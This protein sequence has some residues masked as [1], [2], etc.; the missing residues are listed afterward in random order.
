MERL[1][2]EMI[3]YFRGDARRISHFIKVRSFAIQ[4]SEM[5]QIPAHTREIIETAALVHDI[6]IREAERL[7]GYN[8]GKL[9]EEL[10]PGPARTVLSKLAYKDDMV[11]RV[12]WLIAHHH[13]Y[14]NITD[15]DHQILV[16]ADF[17]VN[18]QEDQADISTIR[19]VYDKIF[20]T[21]SGKL[22]CKEIFDFD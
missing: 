11:E 5:E 14:Q 22:L 2:L 16:E 15:T 7:Y 19:S 3:H 1:V 12:A 13:T 18:L 4:I 17:L 6:G 9:Q 8:N 20:V 21:E 10:G